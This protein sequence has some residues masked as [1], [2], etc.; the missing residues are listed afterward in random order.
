MLDKVFDPFVSSK[1]EGVGLGLVNT[2][3]I[4]ES[5]GGQVRLSPREPAGTCVTISLPV[6]SEPAHAVRA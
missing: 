5:H 2:R 4:V 1:R 6:A 3:S